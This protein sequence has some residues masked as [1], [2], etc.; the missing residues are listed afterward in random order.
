M[1]VTYLRLNREPDPEMPSAYADRRTRT[2]DPLIESIARLGGRARA[3][4]ADLRDASSAPMLFEVAED[5]FGPVDILVNNASAWATDTFSQPTTDRL[6]RSL[7]RVTSETID[8]VFSVDAKAS[9]L[10]ISEFAARHIGRGRTWGRIIALT[11]GGPLGFPEEVSYGA[12]K[13]ALENYT[14]SAAFEL[15]PHGVTA[16]AVHPPVTDTGWVTP[17][18]REMVHGNDEL[19]HIASPEQVA[20]VVVFLSSDAARLVTANV[21]HLR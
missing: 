19:L 8:E 12:A 4:E 13:A 20:E 11:S 21:I 7:T 9:A 15:A 6:G 3:V 5:A 2:A 18:V 17:T 14:M 10:L 1:L 16:N